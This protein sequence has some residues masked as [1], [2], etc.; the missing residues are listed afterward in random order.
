MDYRLIWLRFL[1]K[2]WILPV[3]A[4]TGL[5]LVGAA[6]YY[7]RTAARGGRTYQAETIFYIDFAENLQGEEYDYYNYFTWGEVIHTDFFLD[8]ICETLNGELSVEELSSYISAT[9]DSDVRYLYVRYNTHSPELSLRLASIMEDLMPQFAGQRK[10]IASIEV[11]KAG[12]TAKDSSGV[13]LINACFL[14]ACLGLALSVFGIL[15]SLIVDTAVYL[16]S[17]IERRYHI[18][19]LG[20]PCMPEF[21]PNW[22]RYL[23]GA[24]RVALVCVDEGIRTEDLE[25][26]GA[27]ARPDG[28]GMSAGRRG[29]ETGRE[30]AEYNER[31]VCRNPVEHPEELEKIRTCDKAVLCLT[32]GRKN[33]EAFTRL[34]EQLARQEIPV[35]AAVLISADEKLISAYYRSGI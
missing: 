26:L 21:L 34:M 19:C 2:I 4:L 11:V 20:A 9:V 14:G 10:E 23:N 27:P 33:H 17:T 18:V 5:L 13:R 12:D 31:I 1:R 6:Y 22:Q 30:T 29:E 25:G 8:Q 24:S 15:V 28:D 3:A 16:P 32:A 7:S 35:A